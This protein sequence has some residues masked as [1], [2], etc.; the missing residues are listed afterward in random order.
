M[1]HAGGRG[2]GAERSRAAAAMVGAKRPRTAAARRERVL[3]PPA[4]DAMLP[5]GA[6]ERCISAQWRPCTLAGA[7]LSLEFGSTR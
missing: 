4:V 6:Q 3:R 1:L 2:G 5:P 7:V